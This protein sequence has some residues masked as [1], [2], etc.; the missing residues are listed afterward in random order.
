MLTEFEQLVLLMLHAY[1]DGYTRCYF[2]NQKALDKYKELKSQVANLLWEKID[3]DQKINP[4]LEPDQKLKKLMQ[5]QEQKK[6]LETGAQDPTP[7]LF[8]GANLSDGSDGKA[9]ER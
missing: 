2:I 8:A 6:K 9:G 4:E 7:D 5:M 1:E 3:P